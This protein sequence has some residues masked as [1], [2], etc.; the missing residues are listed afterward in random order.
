M[1]TENTGYDTIGVGYKEHRKIDVRILDALNSLLDLPFGSIVA[2]IGA[3]TGNYSRAL[4][5]KGY[6]IKAVEPSS[7]MRMQSWKSDEVEWLNGFA[8]DIP[9]DND[10]VA[11][12]IVV[13][14]IHHFKSLKV[15]AD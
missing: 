8:E 9:L 7:V 11:G 4:A 14:A 12:I 6:K 3:G 10:S 2:D 13:L 15:A 1:V 5:D